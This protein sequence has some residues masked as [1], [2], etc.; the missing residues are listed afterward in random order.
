[1][2][3]SY[4]YNIFISKPGKSLG[5]INSYRPANLLPVMSKIFKNY[6]LVDCNR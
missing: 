1:M 4:N 6:L 2:K 3:S 5:D